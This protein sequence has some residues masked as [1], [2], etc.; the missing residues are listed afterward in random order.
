MDSG[1]FTLDQ[2]NDFSG[3]VNLQIHGLLNTLG[4]CWGCVQWGVSL[5]ANVWSKR[6]TLLWNKQWFMFYSQGDV[7]LMLR[8]IGMARWKI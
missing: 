8:W 6:G 5:R 1:V 2:G 3:C 7:L 4:V